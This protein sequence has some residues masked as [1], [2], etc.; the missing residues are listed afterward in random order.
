MK[1]VNAAVVVLLALPCMNLF[2]L[3]FLDEMNSEQNPNDILL[4]LLFSSLSELNDC[5]VPLRAEDCGAFSNFVST[6]CAE[7]TD[8]TEPY[9]TLFHKEDSLTA[10]WKCFVGSSRKS[11]IFIVVPASID[12]VEKVTG[13]AE[14]LGKED[15]TKTSGAEQGKLK[16]TEAEEGKLKTTKVEEGKS[17]ATKIDDVNSSGP[18]QSRD[19]ANVTEIEHDEPDTTDAKGCESDPVKPV[20]LRSLPVFIYECKF[21]SV[22]DIRLTVR[23]TQ[24][25]FLDYSSRLTEHLPPSDTSEQIMQEVGKSTELFAYCKSVTERYFQTFVNGVFKSL[26]L[27]F[28]LNGKDVESSVELICEESC[29]EIDITRFIRILCMHYRNEKIDDEVFGYSSDE[30]FI[31]RRA[32]KISS[33]ST[34]KTPRTPPSIT[35]K[36][37]SETVHRFVQDS[38]LEIL[39]KKFTHVPKND[40]LFFYHSE[41]DQVCEIH[42]TINIYIN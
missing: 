18:S 4:S 33:S 7:Q 39:Q 22:S 41:E 25:L 23:P 31:M 8:S 42:P 24:N 26:Q 19:P 11:L 6:R 36:C 9:P 3:P 15:T 34:I 1:R 28:S 5:E 17:K 12:D 27:G 14:S 21:S 32:G 37:G 16:T 10:S 40:D 35:M 30:N 38:F 2:C 13:A 29:L 20:K